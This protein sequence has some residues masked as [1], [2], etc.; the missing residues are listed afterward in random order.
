M[1]PGP[2]RILDVLSAPT[3]LGFSV[4][5]AGCV[6][7][8]CCY[9]RMTDGWLHVTM[10]HLHTSAIERTVPVRFLE[11]GFSA[12]L[13]AIALWA[14]LRAGGPRLRDGTIFSAYVLAASL[15]R[16]ASGYLRGDYE[17][18]LGPLHA[19]QWGALILAVAAGSSLAFL[20]ATR[21]S[22]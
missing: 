16:F 14:L 9:G 3:A 22:T 17:I 2:G 18:V 1:R 12:V 5:K 19:V 10:S 6:L 20:V 13:A 4:S 7:A 21:R 11:M 8:G 15:A